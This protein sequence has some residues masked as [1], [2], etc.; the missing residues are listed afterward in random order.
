MPWI[1]TCQH[2]K[3]NRNRLGTLLL[4]ARSFNLFSLLCNRCCIC[5]PLPPSG[6]GQHQ[7][8]PYCNYLANLRN[9]W[10]FVHITFCQVTHTGCLR[11]VEMVDNYLLKLFRGRRL[12]PAPAKNGFTIKAAHVYIQTSNGCS[13][14]HKIPRI[15]TLNLAVSSLK[16][17]FIFVKTYFCYDS[18]R[19][20]WL[21]SYCIIPVY[22]A[23]RRAFSLS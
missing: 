21:K 12:R 7:G 11:L 20:S 15:S 6:I 13:F 9:F 4:K 17:R 2:S 1:E 19:S 18:L 16:M 8:K 3:L 14:S 23:D 22:S 10:L 5:L